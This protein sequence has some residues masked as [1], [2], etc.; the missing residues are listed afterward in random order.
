MPSTLGS[1]ILPAP[2]AT[3][4]VPLTTCHGPRT[5]R[6][7]R[8][9]DVTLHHRQP[10]VK[11]VGVDVLFVVAQVTSAT[12]S[13]RGSR[14][15]LCRFTTIKEVRGQVYQEHRALCNDAI[16]PNHYFNIV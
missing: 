1:S 11:K 4:T 9:G 6:R 8:A 15:R 2:A 13:I 16:H 10:C 5:E 7:N 3:E 14:P 12:S